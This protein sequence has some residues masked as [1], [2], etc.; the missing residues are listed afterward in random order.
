MI[1]NLYNYCR[2][3]DKGFHTD[4]AL[5]HVFERADRVEVPVNPG[6]QM[7]KIG[8]SIYRCP[9]YALQKLIVAR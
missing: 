8:K 1:P 6:G 7:V 4:N 2:S 9:P 3:L 5:T